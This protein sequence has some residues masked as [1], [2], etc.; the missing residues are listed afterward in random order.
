[1]LLLRAILQPFKLSDCL[2]FTQLSISSIYFC[3]YWKQSHWES[4]LS[5]G[6]WATLVLWHLLPHCMCLSLWRK[7]GPAVGKPR[8]FVHS[9]FCISCV[10]AC[11]LRALGF[12]V[13]TAVLRFLYFWL[14]WV[15][16]ITASGRW[17]NLTIGTLAPLFERLQKMM[18]FFFGGGEVCYDTTHVFSIYLCIHVDY[19]PACLLGLFKWELRCSQNQIILCTLHGEMCQITCSF[20]I[21]FICFINLM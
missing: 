16:E 1:M 4:A 9:N 14:F 13:L 11:L 10:S 21:Q 19:R 2:L 6:G 18:G 17:I 7:P 8:V 20:V 5:F 3:L 12:F 15:A